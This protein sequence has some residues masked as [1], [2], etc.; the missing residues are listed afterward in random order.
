MATHH[1][2]L[3]H[4]YGTN[5][6]AELRRAVRTSA[7]D[8]DAT[9]RT[10]MVVGGFV[11]ALVSLAVGSFALVQVGVAP[12]VSSGAASAPG[13][14]PWEAVA[15]ILF[16]GVGFAAGAALV[17]IGMGRWTSPRPPESGADYTGPGEDAGD[18]PDPPQVV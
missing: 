7:P 12:A 3:S 13:L 18:M 1:A 11:I 16:G 6:R 15:M 4:R 5:P 14:Q 2:S 8:G 9:R 17:G 10:A